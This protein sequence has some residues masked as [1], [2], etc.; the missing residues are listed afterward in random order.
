VAYRVYSAY[1]DAEQAARGV[2]LARQQVTSLERVAELVKLR[3]DDGRARQIE[4][5]KANVDVLDARKSITDF[6]TAQYLTELALAE[7]LG[8]PPGDQVRAAREERGPL[9]VPG[10]EE[11]SV[12]TALA[13]SREIRRL[14][15]NLQAKT[16]EI[17]GYKAERLPKID[18]IW[19]YSLLSRFNNFD[20]FYPRFQRNNAQVGASIQVPLLVGRGVGAATT[21]AEVDIEKIRVEINRTRGRIAG[22]IKRGY[23]E[24]RKAES[25]RNLAREQ[26][27]LA[28][29]QTSQ[30]L[31]EYEGGRVLLAQVE[32]SRAIE[33]SRWM[34]Y[35]EAQR[36]LE[37]ARLNILRQTGTLLAVVQ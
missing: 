8:Y 30:D 4:A 9:V 5:R 13:E 36:A 29:E 22:D 20:V 12:E 28:R 10:T 21:Q 37:A 33:Q 25:T 31:I 18:L 7:L 16:L 32:S 6:E 19:Q 1:L 24:V 34:E 35:Y 14:T 11:E 3:V 23:A 27:D 26:L 15:S 17:K 2:D